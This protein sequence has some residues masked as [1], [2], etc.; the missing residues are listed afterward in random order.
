M[1]PLIRPFSAGLVLVAA[2]VAGIWGGPA[3]AHPLPGSTLTLGRDADSL[4]LTLAIPL[5]DLALAL[6]PISALRDAPPG[7]A[8]DPA[9][10]QVLA[11]YLA[12]HL[13]LSLG[14]HSALA[15]VVTNT[16]LAQAET[17]DVGPYDLIV[18]D[19]DGA[20]RPGQAVFPMAVRFDAVLHEVRNHTATVYWQ[21]PDAGPVAVGRIRFDA[22]L[23]AAT[24]LVMAAAP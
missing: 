8:I 2:V 12:Q 15:L 4:S 21:A 24:P 9:L 23:G 22:D 3:L 16:V 14:E 6:P 10:A 5:Q 13:S 17:P 18:V 11:A 1:W 20:L 19:L 7:A